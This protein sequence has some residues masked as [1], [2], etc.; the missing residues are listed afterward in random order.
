MSAV[1]T[2]AHD[3]ARSFRYRNFR[4]FFFG[5]IISMI[6][7]WAQLVAQAILVLELTDSGSWLGFVTALQFLPILVVGPYAGVMSDRL[8]KRRVMLVT[9]SAMMAC[10]LLLG[11]LV[12]V[13][14]ISLPVLMVV[15]VMAGT[16]WAFDQP[17]RRTLVTEL[18]DE[19]DATNAVSLNG[20]LVNGAKIFGPAVAAGLI[21]AVGVGWCYVFNGLT[22]AAVVT[23]LYRMDP[24]AIRRPPAAS[25]AEQ[26]HSR[27][28]DALRYIWDLPSLRV[29]T[30]LLGWVSVLSFNWNVLMPLIATRALEGDAGTLAVLMGGSSVGGVAGS[31]WTASRH[32][33]GATFV[34]AAAVVYGVSALAVGVAPEIVTAAVA[35]IAVGGFALAFFNG[36][37]AA[38]QLGAAPIMRGRVMA[39]YGMVVLGSNAVGAPLTGWAADTIGS[40]PT[41]ALGGVAASLAGLGSYA[42]LR[43]GGRTDLSPEMIEEATT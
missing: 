6:G 41:A 18:V 12:L 35:S 9:Q 26:E 42:F 14:W 33:V 43:G 20:A 32:S 23:A 28:R 11:F 19:D 31:L 37:V 38:L 3:T 13:D 2:F 21:P 5:Q 27:M 16:A 4:L 7:Y 10:A 15:A 30:L 29:P 36:G 39:V 34:A 8:D 22:S 24:A 25:A 40:R 17:S 1:A